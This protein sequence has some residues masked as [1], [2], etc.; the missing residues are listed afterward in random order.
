MQLIANLCGSPNE[1]NYPGWN[2]LPGVKNAD[3]NGLPDKNPEIPGEKNF[4]NQVRQVK[5]S[6]MNPAGLSM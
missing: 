6:F 4:G 5:Q 2:A 3:P 1:H